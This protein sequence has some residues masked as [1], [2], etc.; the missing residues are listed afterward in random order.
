ME[1]VHRG[2]QRLQSVINTE[3]NGLDYR[4]GAVL[5]K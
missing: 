3:F 4:I 1:Y 5:T 2:T